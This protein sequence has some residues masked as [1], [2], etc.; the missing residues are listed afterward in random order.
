M[1][2][3]KPAILLVFYPSFYSVDSVD[4]ILKKKGGWGKNQ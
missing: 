3:M 4:F 1:V 2:T